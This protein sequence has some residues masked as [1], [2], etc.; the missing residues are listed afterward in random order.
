VSKVVPE[1]QTD[2]WELDA[3]V[4]AVAVL[5]VIVAICCGDI[6]KEGVMVVDVHGWIGL[7]FRFD[8]FFEKGKRP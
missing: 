7:S 8:S 1:A 3:A 5:H 4:A 2:L 6:G